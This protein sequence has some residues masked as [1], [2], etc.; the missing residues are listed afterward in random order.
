MT[1]RENIYL[2]VGGLS[3]GQK[4]KL[5]QKTD[6]IIDFNNAMEDTTCK[7]EQERQCL[8]RF[9]RSKFGV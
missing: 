2:N 3:E 9:F 5:V 1:G 7:V 4:K 6:E 8:L